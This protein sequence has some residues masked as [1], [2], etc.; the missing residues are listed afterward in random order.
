MSQ[1]LIHFDY[2]TTR[3]NHK[4]APPRTVVVFVTHNALEAVYLADRVFVLSARPA[5]IKAAFAVEAPRT[6]E[7]DEPYVLQL[8]R[9]VLKALGVE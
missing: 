6:R 5:R 1:F 7:I 9:A 4:T 3:G 8:Q 2:D